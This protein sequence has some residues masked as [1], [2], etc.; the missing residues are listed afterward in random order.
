MMQVLPKLKE[1]LYMKK[2]SVLN[3]VKLDDVQSI[4]VTFLIHFR[5]YTRAVLQVEFQVRASK[6]NYELHENK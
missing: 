6:I 1:C 3:D 4:K 2:P 5:L